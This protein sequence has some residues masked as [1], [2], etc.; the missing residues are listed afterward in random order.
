MK[1]ASG[2]FCRRFFSFSTNVEGHKVGGQGYVIAHEHVH[3][4]VAVYCDLGCRMF[5]VPSAGGYK[6]QYIIIAAF[7]SCFFF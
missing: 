5:W 7:F 6:W 4:G 1:N 2:E 3:V